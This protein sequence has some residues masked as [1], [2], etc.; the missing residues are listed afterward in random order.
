MKRRC[1]RVFLTFRGPSE[2][3]AQLACAQHLEACHGKDL[4]LALAIAANQ[5]VFA[6]NDDASTDSGH[7]SCQL[8]KASSAEEE[9]LESEQPQPSSAAA[10][11]SGRSSNSSHLTRSEDLEWEEQ[12]ESE[13]SPAAAAER[14]EGEEREQQLEW[15][16]RVTARK[17]RLLTARFRAGEELAR[18]HLA[19]VRA[20]NALE[21][22]E[23]ELACDRATLS[24]ATG[25]A[26]SS[27]AEFSVTSCLA[28]Q[29]VSDCDT[30]SEGDFCG[31]L[32]ECRRCRRELFDERGEKTSGSAPRENTPAVIRTALAASA[33][34]DR[35]QSDAES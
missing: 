18:E 3:A 33:L 29:A 15:A 27:P 28:E 24:L 6:H 11:R 14:E 34:T 26:I 35:Q 4:T 9:P 5:A 21:G 19:F 13:E 2:E 31:D 20:Y 23:E 25:A 17:K 30:V 16:R 7:D 12:L 8:I 32:I 10:A 22:A 1:V